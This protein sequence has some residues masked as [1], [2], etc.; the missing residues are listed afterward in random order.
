[1]NA[2]LF[3]SFFLGGFECSTHRLR[4][5]KRLDMIAATA[6]D[7]FVAEDYLR[8]HAQGIRTA[9]DGI[10]WHLVEKTPGHYDWSSVLPMLRAARE[11]GTQVIWD[12]CHY[13]WPDD[14]PIFKPAFV[15]RFACIARAF[16]EVLASETDATPFICPMNEISFF[17]WGGGDVG[18]LNPFAMKR[19]DALK[20]QLVRATIAATEAIWDVIPGARIV[21]IDP[22]IH[23]VP[24]PAKPGT[25]E[26]VEGYVRSQYD[27]W[28]MIAGRQHP[29]LGGQER[30]LDIIGVNYY[31]RNQW[32]DAG[33]ILQ[34]ADAEYRPLRHLLND[35]YGRY[36][37]PLFVAETGTEDTERPEWLRYVSNE[38]RAAMHAG[39]PVEGICLYPIVNHPGWDN[40]RH[41]H[42]GLWD[43]AD[44]QGRREIYQPLARELRRQQHL[45]E[46]L[47]ARNLAEPA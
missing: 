8:L 23:I 36:Q 38:V 12:L 45:F 19:G 14:I 47:H 16:A 32:V 11:T 5:G 43:Y 9:R 44:E 2:D 7:H 29:Y 13:G 42:N 22:L 3:Q 46:P 17:A 25:H 41:C 6:H 20:V 28:E 37:R 4:S 30:Y 21:H 34:P 15:E 33:R 27:G 31:P 1:M 18:Y 24:N 39:I 26:Q 10:R 35:V 40:E